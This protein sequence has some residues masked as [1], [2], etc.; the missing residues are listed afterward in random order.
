[1]RRFSIDLGSKLAFGIDYPASVAIS[2]RGDLLAYVTETDGLRGIHV[3]AMDELEARPLGGTVGAQQPFFSPDGKWLG[4]FAEG[5][6]KK[7]SVR[8]G[9][10]IALAE[11]PNGMGGAWSKDGW[12]VFAPSDLSGLQRVGDSGGEVETFSRVKPEA[13]EQAHWSPVLIADQRTVLFTVYTGGRNTESRLAIQ[14]AGQTDHRIVL[15]GGSHGRILP[16]HW[17]IYARGTELLAVEFDITKDAVTG[18]PFRVL[19]GVQDTPAAGAPLFAVSDQGTLVYVRAVTTGFAGRVVWVDRSGNAREEIDAGHTYGRPRLSPDG[20]RVAFHFADPDFNVWVKELVRGTR[21]KLTKEPGWDGFAVWS[22]DGRQIAFSSAREGSRTL[23][24]QAADG[25]GTAERLLP[26][27]NP[28]WPTSWS[29]DGSWLAFQEE[30][31][32]TGWDVWLLDLRSRTAS[33]FLHTGAREVWGRF[34]NDGQWL[35]YQSNESGSSEVYIASIRDRA[36]RLQV[37]VGG[38]AVPIWSPANDGMYYSQG[39]EFLRVPI[40][41]APS[42]VAG[43]PHRLFGIE[44]LEI[45]DVSP[46]GDRFIA[47]EAPKTVAINRLNV[48]L[49]W[50]QILAR[51]AETR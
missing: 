33:S 30:D 35:A 16:P 32:R 21:W 7:V 27:G 46:S 13:G 14:A 1:V 17:L 18:T 50:P 42:P 38:G 5:K 36:Q 28:R 19:E 51:L 40:R 45:N 6:L 26:V 44:A 9:A 12:I 49:G 2:P 10:P 34:S 47:V 11:A 31:P 4:F 37:S 25:T 15:D 41:L 22:P 29:R 48:V 8:G 43:R 23:F 20:T 24:L 39:A 3:R